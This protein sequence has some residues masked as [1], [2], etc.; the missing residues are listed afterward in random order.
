MKFTLNISESQ[1]HVMNPSCCSYREDRLKSNGKT[2]RLK[3]VP[4][5]SLIS[6]ALLSLHNVYTLYKEPIV[7]R[8]DLPPPLRLTVDASPIVVPEK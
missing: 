8:A 2:R 5:S 7:N 4:T 3:S 1:I 6:T